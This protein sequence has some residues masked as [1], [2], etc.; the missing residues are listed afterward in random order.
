MNQRK[1][2]KIKENNFLMFEIKIGEGFANCKQ[3]LDTDEET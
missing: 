1:Q 2:K 3:K